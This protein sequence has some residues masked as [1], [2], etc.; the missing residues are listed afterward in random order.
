MRV[1]R[2]RIVSKFEKELAGNNLAVVSAMVLGDRSQLSKSLKDD[3]S[4]SGASHVLALSGLHLAVVYGLL[5]L[6]LKGL[7]N[8]LPVLR[9]KGLREFIILF[10]VWGICHI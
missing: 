4:I 8:L 6:L 9:R 10:T 7:S 2:Q 1:Y 5:L 3:Y